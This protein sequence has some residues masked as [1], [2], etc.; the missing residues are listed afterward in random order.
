MEAIPYEIWFLIHEHA[1]IIPIYLSN[2]YYYDLLKPIIYHQ[3]EFTSRKQLQLFIG[4]LDT[5]TGSLVAHLNVAAV[6][7]RCNAP[8]YFESWLIFCPL[9]QSLELDACLV[10]N[11]DVQMI[12]SSLF[13]LQHLSL[14]H[15]TQITNEGIVHLSRLNNLQSLDLSKLKMLKTLFNR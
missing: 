10:T 3:P 12:S 2:H 7:Y 14:C 9:L 4:H 8:L 5:K 15:C 13:R 1:S 11:Q 6:P